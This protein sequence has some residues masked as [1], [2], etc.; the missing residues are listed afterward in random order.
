[1]VLTAK[2]EQEVNLAILD[3]LQRH[4]YTQAATVFCAESQ[5]AASA[6]DDRHAELL[7]KKWGAV[8]RLQKKVMQLEERLKEVESEARAP[9]PKN[10]TQD[11]SLWV[12][13]PPAA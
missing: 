3:Y 10:A 2:Q 12:P 5:T 4:N 6:L 1:M 9:R 11:S 7:D 13:R 8:L